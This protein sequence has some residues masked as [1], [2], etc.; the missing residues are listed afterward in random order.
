MTT[1]VGRCLHARLL[2]VHTL[3]ADYHYLLYVGATEIGYFMSRLLDYLAS[4]SS[5]QSKIPSDDVVDVCSEF[6]RK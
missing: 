6:F 5:A 1:L 3:I 2:I 4:T